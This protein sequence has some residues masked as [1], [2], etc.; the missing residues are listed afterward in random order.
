MRLASRPA[1]PKGAIKNLT[2]GI[3]TDWAK[4]SLQI[5]A[6]APGYFKTPA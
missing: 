5:N 4:Y 6:I 3:C 1:R 2:R